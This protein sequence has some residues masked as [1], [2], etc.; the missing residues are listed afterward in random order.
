[1]RST[2]TRAAAA[3]WLASL[4]FAG[5]CGCGGDTAPATPLGDGAKAASGGAPGT[6]SG[7]VRFEGEVPAPRMI[8]VNKDATECAHAA[9]EVQEVV[10]SADGGLAGVV[11]EIPKLKAP[12]GSEW[13]PAG[14]VHV[15]RQ[16]GCRFHPRVQV[17][18]NRAELTVYNDDPLLHNV[19]TGEWNY[20]QPNNTGPPIKAAVHFQGRPFT[21]VNC[22]VHSWMDAWIYVARSPYYAV[23]DTD[24]RFRLDGVPAGTHELLVSHPTLGSQKFQ[25][26]VPAGGAVEQ[27]VSF[28]AGG[29]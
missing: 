20:G 12:Q 16:T 17:V 23:S 15:L 21:H 7:R 2:T 5:I 4:L 19:N 11:V 24:G 27:A 9:G 1:M 10:V 8:Q 25:V 22:N 28:R 13:P 29:R 3:T 18:P 26:T 6:V 14:E